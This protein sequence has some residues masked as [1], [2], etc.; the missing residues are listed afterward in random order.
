MV[1]LNVIIAYRKFL[2]KKVIKEQMMDKD[3]VN[4]LDLYLTI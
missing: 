4:Y 2:F 1:L 3:L